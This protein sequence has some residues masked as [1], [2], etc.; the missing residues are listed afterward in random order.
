[1]KAKPSGTYLQW[2]SPSARFVPSD[3]SADD[4]NDASGCEA[5]LSEVIR[6]CCC[7]T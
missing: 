4:A 3:S 2:S 6:S 5:T 1:V 7:M